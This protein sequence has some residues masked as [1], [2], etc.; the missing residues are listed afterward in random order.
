MA[1]D[2]KILQI[3]KHKSEYLKVIGRVP[4]ESIEKTTATILKDFGKYFNKFPTHTRIDFKVFAPMFGAWH[5]KLKVE[6]KQ[7]YATIFKE[8]HRDVDEAE[9]DTILHSMLELRLSADLANILMKW[10]EGDLANIHGSLDEVMTH[11]VRDA[12]VKGLDF[13]RPDVD[14]LL[15]DEENDVG[16]RWRLSCLNDSMRALR[17][18]DFGILAAR[19]DKG[20]TTFLASEITFMAAQTKKNVLWLNNE[21]PGN[22]IYTRLWQ[23][24]LG[25]PMSE[26]VKLHQQ[27][28][29]LTQYES[30]IKGDQFKIK[31]FDIHG[32]DTYA[33]E[34]IIEQ[35]EPGLVVYDMIDKVRGFA[36]A[37]RTDLGLEKMYDW[38]RD[39]GVKHDFAGMASSQISA[40]GANL[41]YP[42]D[43][44]L[45]D[46]KTGKQGAC[47]WIVMI[48]AVDDPG[49]KNTRFIG[50]PKN[51]LRREGAEG[52]P[53]KP[54][55]FKPQIARFEDAEIYEE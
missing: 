9:K 26:I 14:A 3:L 54:V 2:L 31:V 52:N 30:A 40:D 1:V 47:D 12:K 27:G 18:G 32:M 55:N 43:H 20:K 7:Q 10:E 51:K 42:S 34:R 15:A 46:S 17:G 41:Q 49:Y 25:L 39:L 44:M 28:R 4:T 53:Q 13:I 37:A 16:L 24:A 38:A 6:Q 8:A 23:A 21:G 36:D 48:G 33:V 50:A 45:K 19:P 35:H 22:R 11:F 29:L 5:S